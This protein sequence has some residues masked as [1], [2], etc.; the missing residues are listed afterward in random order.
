MVRFNFQRDS[1]W[2]AN[3]ELTSSVAH[4]RSDP[5]DTKFLFYY[6]RAEGLQAVGDLYNPHT[7]SA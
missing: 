7:T 4:D 3:D 1:N 5:M 2:A 6:S